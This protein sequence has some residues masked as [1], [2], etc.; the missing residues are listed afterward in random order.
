MRRFATAL[1]MLSLTASVWAQQASDSASLNPR[2]LFEKGMNALAGTGTSR[3]EQTALDS[4]RR[5]AELGYA[6]AQDALGYFYETGTLAPRDTQEALLWYRKAAEQGDR[7]GQW[8]LGRAYFT[9]AGTGRDPQNTERWLRQAAE[10]GDPFAQYLLALFKQERNDYKAAAE[11]FH[12]AAEQG[13]PQSQKQLGLLLKQGRGI[14]ENKVEAYIWLLLSFEAGNHTVADD[15]KQLEAELGSNQVELVKTQGRDRQQTVSRTVV[16]H[17][18]T[19]WA[20]EF[21]DVPAP[22]PPDLQ[23][24]CR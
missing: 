23:R 5:S 12:K 3:N 11:W 2:A 9:G 21:S 10:Q 13:L 1:I 19:G 4:I 22:P 20:G 7:L 8:L 18:C 16:A 24:F 6:P 17:G 15:L 14:P